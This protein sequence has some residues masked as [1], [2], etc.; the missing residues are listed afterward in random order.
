VKV[1]SGAF[2][3]GSKIIFAT[4]MAFALL[5]ASMSAADARGFRHGGPGPVLGL[6]GG[7][8]VGAATIATLPFVI[9]A[10][11]ARPG[12]AP[13]DYYGQDDRGY[14][15]P[16]NYYGGQPAYG[17]GYGPP[18]PPPP[19]YYQRDPRYYGPPPDYYGPPPGYY[20]Y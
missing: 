9:L 10:D 8:I 12:P 5:A 14:G 18:P 16:P 6:L 3:R 20:G 11:A 17:P 1:N 7:V 2:M 15:P 19:S 13:P 4:L